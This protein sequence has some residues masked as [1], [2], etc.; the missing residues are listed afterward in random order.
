MSEV[1]H[2]PS[3]LAPVDRRLD[4]LGEEPVADPTVDRRRIE[5]FPLERD[6]RVTTVPSVSPTMELP[7]STSEKEEE[8]GIALSLEPHSYGR[9]HCL[10]SHSS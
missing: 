5:G 9:S 1:E 4:E 8:E 2:R 6:C 10:R 7:V 3:V